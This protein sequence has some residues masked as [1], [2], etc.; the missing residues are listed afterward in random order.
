MPARGAAQIDTSDQSHASPALYSQ[1]LVTAGVQTPRGS[2]RLPMGGIIVGVITTVVAESALLGSLCGISAAGGF[3]WQFSAGAAG[4]TC[5]GIGAAIGRMFPTHDKMIKIATIVFSLVG[6]ILTGAGCL[7]ALAGYKGTQLTFT[8]AVLSSVEIAAVNIG[9]ILGAS[10]ALCIVGLSAIAV[11]GY[12]KGPKAST[13]ATSGS[14]PGPA[15]E[16]IDDHYSDDQSGDSLLGISVPNE[17]G[18]P[19]PAPERA[20]NPFLT[21]P[22]EEGSHAFSPPSVPQLRGGAYESPDRL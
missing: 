14:G 12:F 6:A 4:G 18:T 7:V 17:P 15:P 19:V 13:P 3:A 9:L 8:A 21:P 16:G 22:R 2:L 10:F 5:A 11:A 20:P 1:M